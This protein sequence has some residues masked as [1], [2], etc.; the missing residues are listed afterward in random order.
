MLT[1]IIDNI[2]NRGLPRSP[3]ARELVTQLKGRSVAIAIDG[4]AR[5]R[6]ESDGMLLHVATASGAAAADAT[7][8]GGPLALLA[9][10]RPGAQGVVQRGAVT[11]SG[12]G[13]LAEQFQELA[14]LLQPDFEE[15][16]SLLIGDVPAHQ[17]ARWTGS[18]GRWLRNAA[19]TTFVNAAEY[20]AHER[21]D[22]VPRQEGEQFLHGVDAVR[23]AVDR[24]E[25]RLTLLER[26]R[27]AR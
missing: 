24:L 17:L 21:A 6:V 15:E 4:F 23:E 25:A 8:C 11:I 19:H 7:L 26:R 1:R 10:M 3:R 5:V 22:L 12:D 14:R 9:L 18:G 2:V 27:Q 16:L 20:L 13:Q